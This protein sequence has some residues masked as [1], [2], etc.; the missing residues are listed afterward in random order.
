MVGGWR[1][2]REGNRRVVKN[3]YENFVLRCMMHHLS[4]GFTGRTSMDSYLDTLGVGTV[5]HHSC[6]DILRYAS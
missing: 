4:Q 1:K 5:E 6:T 3:N 2:T